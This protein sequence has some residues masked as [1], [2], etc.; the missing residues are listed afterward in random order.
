[1]GFL[2]GSDKGIALNFLQASKKVQQSPWLWLIKCSGKM[3]KVKLTEPEKEAR[4]VK[5]KVIIFF[6][7]K[8]IV[9]KNSSWCTKQTIPHNTVTFYDDCMEIC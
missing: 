2:N 6:H 8:E 7:I 3:E 4:H 5:S 9:T 1:M